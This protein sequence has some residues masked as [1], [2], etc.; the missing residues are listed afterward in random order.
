[1]MHPLTGIPMLLGLL[2]MMWVVLGQ[3]VAGG[4]VGI[5]EGTIMLGYW[6]PFIQGVVGSVVPPG[7]ALYAVLV[8]EFGVLTMAPTYLIGVILPLV[9]GFYLLLSLL[10]DSGYLRRIAA[11]S[12]RSLTAVGLNGR[13]I[14][15][16]I[17]G[18]GC[19]TM[20]TLT[21][22]ILGSSASASSPP[23]SWRSRF[24]VPPRSL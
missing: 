5:T 4:V 24:R 8:G 22:R 21:T 10:E 20:G 19:I 23:R 17:L 16:M 9:I 12:D 7:S 2:Y 11:L 1:M 18:L 13:A 3:W 6:V 15:P 14:I